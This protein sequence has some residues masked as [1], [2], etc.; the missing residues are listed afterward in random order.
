MKIKVF[1]FNKNDTFIHKLSGASKL[2]CFLL[3]TS[4][5]MFTYDI[6]VFITLLVISAII[7]K[8]AEIKLDQIKIIVI[9]VG[10]FL[11]FNFFFS[12]IFSPN[13]GPELYG[14]HNS[15]YDFGFYILTYEQV[16]YQ[17]SKFFKYLSVV[18]LG[19][20][21]FMTTNP[22]EFASSLNKIKVNY[23]ICTTLSITLRYFP[24][25]QRDYNTI[26]LAQQAR[27]LDMSKNEK[28]IKRL[29]NM[30]SILSPLIFTTLERVDMIA[31][32]MELRGY[33][34]YKKRTWYSYRPFNKNDYLSILFCLLFFLATMYIRIFINGGLHY[35]PFI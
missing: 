30:T 25:V 14:T 24:D 10:A 17:V 4:S 34:K 27:G 32:A 8:V 20:A 15:L 33:G 1:D 9:S 3:L 11:L 18:P 16:F 31:N 21:F 2:I 22:S 23:K 26:S 7:F 12:F 35:N 28:L 19:I 29:K 13:F 5:I 6:R